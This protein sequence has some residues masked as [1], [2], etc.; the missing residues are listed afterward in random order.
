MKTIILS[1]IL[2][3]LVTC[4]A[5]AHMTT[6]TRDEQPR[7]KVS[8]EAVVNVKPDKI[9][10]VFGVETYEKTIM[11]AKNKSSGIMK[12]AI[13]VARECGVQGKDIQT[14]TLSIEPMYKPV[15]KED[16]DARKKI[17]E[18][19]VR[20]TFIV[21]LSDPAKVEELVTKELEAGVNYIHDIDFQ[22]SALKAYREQAREL[23]LKAAKEKAHKMAAALGQTV[24]QAI[25]VQEDYSGSPWSY[26]SSWRWWGGGRQQAM[27]QNV[28]QNIRGSSPE[29][30][31]SIALGKLSIRSSVSVVFELGK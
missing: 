21:T 4:T 13:A 26:Y 5:W 11:D 17:V 14:D 22:T 2:S 27:S 9:V 1:V 16:E 6:A 12:K 28:T 15:Y 29:V 24:G 8:G 23:A 31:D 18:Y 30:S 3:S 7:I 19:V 20:N 10:V 25:E